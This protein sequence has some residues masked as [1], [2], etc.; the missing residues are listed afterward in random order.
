FWRN[1]NFYL[2]SRGGIVL[3]ISIVHIEFQLKG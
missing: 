3:E 2:Y 1:N